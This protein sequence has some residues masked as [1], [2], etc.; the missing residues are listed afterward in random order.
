MKIEWPIRAL[1]SVMLVCVAGCSSSGS[2]GGPSPTS[3][4]DGDTEVSSVFRNAEFGIDIDY[5]VVYAQGLSHSDWNAPDAVP[6]DLL[7]DVYSPRNDQVDRPAMVFIHGGGFTGGDKGM[8]APASFARFFAERGFV[9]L[10]IN[11]R[12]LGDYGTVPT[13]FVDAVDAFPGLTDAERDQ[14]KAMYP[15]VRDAK[16]ALRWLVAHASDYGVDTDQIGVIGGSAGSFISIAL[17]ATD[18]DDYTNEISI[19]EDST[20]STTHLGE[21]VIVAAVVDHWGGPACVDLP[22]IVDGRARWS[23]NDAPL[24]IVHGTEDL[25]VSYELAETL[26]DIYTDTGAYHELTTLQGAGHGA[27]NSTVEGQAL[28]DIAFDF[29]VRMIGVDVREN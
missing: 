15:A 29:V 23:Q 13:A 9:S 28:T 2:G 22:Q 16:A 19:A 3:A 5:D 26:A 24:S 1:V 4:N 21:S 8:D 25:T 17:G 20:L 11:Y 7:L 12:L 10:S 14:T 18:L 6:M 27:W